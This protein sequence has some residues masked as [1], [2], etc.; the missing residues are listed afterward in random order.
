MDILKKGFEDDVKDGTAEV[1]KHFGGLS[2]AERAKIRER[3]TKESGD[4]RVGSYKIPNPA[5]G[6][7]STRLGSGDYN[8]ESGQLAVKNAFIEGYRNGARDAC[9]AAGDPSIN[10]SELTRNA[11]RFNLPKLIA[12]MADAGLLQA[13][14]GEAGDRPAYDHHGTSKVFDATYNEEGMDSMEPGEH[15][16]QAHAA[17][18]SARDLDEDDAEGRFGEVMTACAHLSRYLDKTGS[19]KGDADEIGDPSGEKLKEAQKIYESRTH[20]SDL[21]R[22]SVRIASN[23][24]KQPGTSH[25]SGFPS[26]KV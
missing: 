25:F 18:T 12:T 15:L 8:E 17:L 2:P 26:R 20:A 7:A 10:P 13:G 21:Q 1:M 9:A 19:P 22:D 3:V 16:D 23:A 6:P 5:S 14:S 11:I 4:K 24:S